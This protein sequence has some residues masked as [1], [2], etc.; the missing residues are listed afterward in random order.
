MRHLRLG[1]EGPDVGVLQV[2][3]EYYTGEVIPS[4][5]IFDQRT[6]LVLMQYQRLRG[7]TDRIGEADI[8]TWESMLYPSRN[9]EQG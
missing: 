3:L 4:R 2:L 1:D 9:Q 7:V 5:D 8:L 6:K